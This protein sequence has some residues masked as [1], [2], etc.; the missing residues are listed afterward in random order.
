LKG[1]GLPKPLEEISDIVHNMAVRIHVTEIHPEL[2]DQ[3]SLCPSEKGLVLLRRFGFW[4]TV[5]FSCT[6]LAT[7][8]A[9]LPLFTEGFVNGG[10]AGLVYGFLIAWA[11][12][13]STFSVIGEMASLAPTAGGQYH[14]VFILAPRS[15]RRVLS[16]ITGW[17]TTSAW[18][19]T[20]AAGGFIAGTTIQGLI[21]LNCPSYVYE[22]FHGTAISWVV[23]FVAMCLNI[24]PGG[25]LPKIEVV[26]MIL[27]VVT[28]FGIL[29]P[30]IY[31][32][33]RRSPTDVFTTF[34]NEGHW[35]FQSISFL[36]GLIGSVACFVGA[37]AT[38]HLSE[39]IQNAAHDVPWAIFGTIL[40]NGGLGLAMLLALL[41]CM[42]DVDKALYAPTHYPYIEI[43]RQGTGSAIGCTVMVSIVVAL[44]MFA[45]V[46]F[47][48]S[49]SRVTWSFARDQGFPFSRLI[50]RVDK[51]TS[52][53]VVAILVVTSTACL[54][55]L[56]NIGSTTVFNDVISLSVS[57]FYA[58]YF[59]PSAL[60]LWHRIRGD[61][62]LWEHP[63]R[64]THDVSVPALKWGP[65]RVPD[66]FGIINNLVACV[67]MLTVI[68][69]SFWPPA[70]PTTPK[71]MN[72]SVLMTGAT[73]MF[74]IVYYATWGRK[75]YRGPKKIES[76]A[77]K[78]HSIRE[79]HDL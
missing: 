55:F 5:G 17:L 34:I 26:V 2:A 70:T 13:L 53:P 69:W 37:D 44:T 73:T 48:A 3:D 79:L 51:Q 12:S 30:L 77:F 7:W 11:G 32:A 59:I 4:S 24:V 50:S 14:W 38:V 66:G 43:L 20:L 42:Q 46:G 49:T 65:W 63:Q 22:P 68:F 41:F 75:T 28:F 31:L 16:Y 40:L 25:T 60:L 35:P 27:H 67:W 78:L 57:G 29:I 8:E 15:S 39:E 36:I 33:P 71:T 62:A 6:T 76:Q 74:S 23:L 56:I 52:Y 19:S 9:I 18:V 72:Y 58:S 21:V 61:I 1:E 47:L 10:P 45:T 54:L 64:D